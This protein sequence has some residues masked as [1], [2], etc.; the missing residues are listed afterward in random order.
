[1]LN[2]E[3]QYALDCILSGENVFLTGN[4]GT[5]KSFVISEAIDMLEGNKN[6]MVC[7]PTGIAALNING[8]TIHRAF[9]VPIGPLTVEPI[10]VSKE[11]LN[12]DVVIIDEVSMCRADLF[13]FISRQIREASKMRVSMA[14][15]KAE[16]QVVVVG[17]FFQLP[18]VINGRE[19]EVLQSYYGEASSYYAFKS[20]YWKEFNF[21]NIVLHQVIRQSDV[22][23][24][25]ALDKVRY[26]DITGASYFNLYSSKK[27]IENAIYLC[28]TNKAADEYNS[29]QFNKINSEAVSFEASQSGEVKES[30][31]CVPDII[32]LKV[33]ARV[34]LM[35]NCCGRFNGEMGT[36]LEI[37]KDSASVKVSMDLGGEAIITPNT[38]EIIGYSSSKG[39]LHKKVIGKYTQIPL[40]IGYAITI[41]KSQGQT[42][43]AININPYSWEYGQLYVGLSRA[44]SI[45]NMHLTQPIKNSYLKAAPDVLSFYNRILNN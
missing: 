27:S 43:E 24:C 21:T 42:Y 1:M 5:G 3:Q 23:I 13:R 44:K 33:G 16:I 4:A 25:T 41:H 18:P 17:D 31:K 30:D 22:D 38:W 40:R 45:Y 20:I 2:N 26:G 9:R 28:G 11:L 8:A 36:I 34:I 14:T 39:K 12:T 15:P 7:A 19:K 10:S 6:V 35:A 32:E 37:N 29:V